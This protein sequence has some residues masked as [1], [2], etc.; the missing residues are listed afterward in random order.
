MGP[1]A[2]GKTTS[3]ACLANS[4]IR[5]DQPAQASV[6]RA[7]PDAAIRDLPEP[8]LIDEW[9]TADATLLG[10]VIDT[11]AMSQ[12][13]VLIPVSNS[14]PRLF[15]VRR[16]E[17]THEIDILVEYGG[18]RVFAFEIRAS[19]APRKSDARHLLWLRG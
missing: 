13:R 8:I 11:F 6:V 1:R 7:D 17:G 10:Q 3:A 12:L 14:L 15:H 18:G 19:S 2:T 16:S 9:Q 4:V 5:L